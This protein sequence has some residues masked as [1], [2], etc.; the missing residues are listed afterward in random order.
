MMK[1]QILWMQ[2]T[3]FFLFVS[4]QSYDIDI[5]DKKQPLL[6]SRPKAREVRAR[7][8]DDS[9]LLLIPEL[10]TRTGVCVYIVCVY[11]CV[12]VYVCVCIW[13]TTSPPST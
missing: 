6:L 1:I 10:C 11:V 7:G 5:L 9:P 12:Y 4:L 8:G 3:V 2:L 13:S